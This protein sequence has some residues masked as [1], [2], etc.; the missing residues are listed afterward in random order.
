MKLIDHVFAEHIKRGL[1]T[2]DIL[3]LMEHYGLIAKFLTFSP[4]SKTE[5]PRYFVPAQLTSPPAKLCEK[6]P[7]GN[8]PCSLYLTFLDGF[9]PHGLFHQLLSRCIRWCSERGFQKEPNLYHCGARF[10]IGKQPIYSLILICSKGSIKVVLTQINP[11]S[12]SSPTAPKELEP[13]EVRVFLDDTLVDLSEKLPWLCSLKYK[14]CVACTGCK[15]VKHESICCTHEECLHLHPVDS[16]EAP[17]I[18]EKSFDDEVV[19][20]PGLEKWFQVPQESEVKILSSFHYINCC[21]CS[22]LSVG[23]VSSCL[24]QMIFTK[25]IFYSI[26]GI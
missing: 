14:W 12:G 17:I 25:I 26:L 11:S 22:S 21:C 16:A 8:D 15:C 2:K 24:S 1:E 4:D 19:K 3:N 20:V 23:K 7:S 5:E 9:V 6:K 18:C 13:G 10:F